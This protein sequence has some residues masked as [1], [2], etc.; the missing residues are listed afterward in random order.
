MIA[1]H[2]ERSK[3]QISPDLHVKVLLPA[4]DEDGHDANDQR[5]N[6]PD[7][8]PLGITA[9]IRGGVWIR[10]TELFSF[11]FFLTSM[12]FGFVMQQESEINSNLV[13]SQ[14]SWCVSGPL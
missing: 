4:L 6:G 13:P 9:Q 5:H 11:N 12:L 8:N 3:N 14:V 2:E 1:D 10:V 7:E